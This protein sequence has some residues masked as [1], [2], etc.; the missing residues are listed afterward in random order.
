MF[1]IY[2]TEVTTHRHVGT[3]SSWMVARLRSE[4]KNWELLDCFAFHMWEFSMVFV[5][6]A[7]TNQ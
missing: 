7:P 2:R 5:G 3:L 6:Q 4:T 1:L